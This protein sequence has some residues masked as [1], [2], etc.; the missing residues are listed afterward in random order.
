MSHGLFWIC[1]FSVPFVTDTHSA[2][3]IEK[4]MQFTVKQTN[5]QLTDINHFLFLEAIFCFMLSVLFQI[6]VFDVTLQQLLHML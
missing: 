4:W 2:Y 5:K 6:Y 1:S 3:F